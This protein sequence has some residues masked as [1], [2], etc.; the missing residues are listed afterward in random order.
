MDAV[1][2]RLEADEHVAVQGVHWAA[3]IKAWGCA[4]KDLDKAIALFESIASHPSNRRATLPDAVSFEALIDVLATH[5][6]TDLIPDY[7]NRLKSS[8]VH[9]TAYIANCLI[10]G[11]AMVGDVEQA[12]SVFE[13]LSDPPAGVAAPNNH[14]PHEAS[15]ASHIPSTTPVY[16]EVSNLVSSSISV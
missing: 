9:M 12:R 8:G 10:K 4:K 2:N 6:R 14:L 5:R 11:F 3:V 7:V 15:P 16:R 1:F 13:Q